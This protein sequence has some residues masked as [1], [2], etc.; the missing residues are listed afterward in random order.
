MSQQP[1]QVMPVIMPWPQQQ[2]PQ[3]SQLPFS[4]PP[5]RVKVA[6]EFLSLLTLKT[7]TRMG[8]GPS[9]LYVAEVDGQKLTAT[10]ESAQSSACS[11][12]ESYF[13]GKLRPDVWEQLQLD[14]VKQEARECN[15]PSSPTGQPGMLMDCMMCLHRGKKSKECPMCK[16]AYQVL[17]F[18]TL[19]PPKEED[20]EQL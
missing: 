14:L 16:G 11:M 20:D 10:E 6:L 9:T 5:C 13:D 19:P 18:P 1:G 2:Q 3:Q 12:L 4:D 17:I 8:A 15:M 7:M